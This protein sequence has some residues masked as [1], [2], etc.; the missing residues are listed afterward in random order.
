MTNEIQ[1][2]LHKPEFPRAAKYDADWMLENQMG[3]NALWLTEWLTTFLTLS[4]GMRVLD[5]GCG[6]AMSSIFLAREFNVQ[7]WAADLWMAPDNNW[8]RVVAAGME[9]QVFPLRTE[10]HQLPFPRGFFDVV[11]SIDA[12]QYFGTDILYLTYLSNFVKSGGVMATVMPGLTK[13][14]S[15]GIPAH[16]VTPQS[17]GSA[18]WE[19]DCVC[20]KTAEWWRK[21]WDACGYVKDVQADTQPDGWRHW[22]DFEMALDLTGKNIFPS[23]VEAL[24]RDAGEYIGFVRLQAVRTERAGMNLY[25]PALGAQT[26]IDP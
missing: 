12:Y 17:N 16:L 4:P 9:S 5:L 10:A 6:R 20:F 21:H 25:D 19:E 15:D 3:P 18:F 1:R 23:C 8:Q 22:R 11:I 24:E 14:F 26:G 2:L 7:V 13:E